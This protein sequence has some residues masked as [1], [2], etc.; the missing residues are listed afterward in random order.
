[1]DKTLDES[2]G[3]LLSAH[4]ADGAREARDLWRWPSARS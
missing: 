3:L 4:G 2:V 1:M